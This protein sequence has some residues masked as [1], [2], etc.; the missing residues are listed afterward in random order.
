M[1]RAAAL[2]SPRAP[3]KL[4]G[5]GSALMVVGRPR[6]LVMPPP[7][8]SLRSGLS[9]RVSVSHSTLEVMC[10]NQSIKVQAFIQGVRVRID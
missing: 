10:L 2:F 9:V 3:R 1:V 8:L 5:R 6:S 4:Y 7:F